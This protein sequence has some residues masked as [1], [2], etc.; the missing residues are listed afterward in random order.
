MKSNNENKKH[1]LIILLI[2]LILGIGYAT[3]KTNLNILGTTTIKNNNFTIKFANIVEKEGSVTPTKA[4][5]IG[6]GDTSLSFDVAL[7]SPGDY[8]GFNVD[9][10]NSGTLNAELESFEI[11]ELTEA[12]QKYLTYE[13][14]YSNGGAVSVG[15]ILPKKSTNTIEVLITYKENPE[16]YPTSSEQTLSF[17]FEVNYVETERDNK[18]DGSVV[19]I[20]GDSISTLK[21][22][23]PSGNRARYVQT[24]AEATGGLLY[25][26]Y[27]ETWWGQVINENNMV[28]GINDSWAGSRVS[29][30]STTNSG[31]YGPDAAMASMTRLQKL[32]DNGTPDLILFYGGTNDIGGAVTMGTFDPTASYATTLNTTATTYTNFVEAYSMA[33]LRM[34]YLYPNAEIV[35]MLPTYT[36]SYY[37]LTELTTYNAE[38]IKICEHFDLKYIDLRESGITTS[39]LADGIHPNATGMDLISD[40]VTE[41]LNTNKS[42]TNSDSSSSNNGA[43]VERTTA[44]T[45]AQTLPENL[46]STT[47]LYAELT[48]KTGYYTATGYDNSTSTGQKAV[49]IVIPV[50]PGDK[51][52]SSSF[53]DSTPPTGGQAGIRVTYLKD[54]TI[55]SSFSPTEVNAEYVVNN[56]LTVPAGVNA[57]SIAW[58]EA[59]DTNWAYLLVD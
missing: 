55:V 18:Y 5:T 40:Y 48:P 46:T 16:S 9:V 36:S 4:A 45:Y 35:V 42:T 13:V 30:T 33:I 21:G 37:T 50:V 28:L 58:W 38:I 12:Q 22:Y 43:D 49:S 1:I 24:E 15:D 54:N 25:M 53:N 52:Q 11:T 26:P 31:D 8:Y 23:I 3:L 6:S 56:Y 14:K 57:I 44:N 47:N 20:L 39:H 27:E 17:K 7:E 10:V 32:D 59:D 29:N 41:K 19:S 34:E 2:I 51:I